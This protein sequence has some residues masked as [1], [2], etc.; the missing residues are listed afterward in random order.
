MFTIIT[1]ILS[2]RDLELMVT[3]MTREKYKIWMLTCENHAAV[4]NL[5][6]KA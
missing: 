4:F 3:T 5:K 6:K 2:G 1:Y